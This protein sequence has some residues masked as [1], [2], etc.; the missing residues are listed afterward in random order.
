MCR[1]SLSIPNQVSVGPKRRALFRSV[2]REF[3]TLALRRSA[4]NYLEGQFAT[5]GLDEQV[6]AVHLKSREIT[7]KERDDQIES[8]F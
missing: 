6:G 1:Q 8:L 2:S 3:T 5:A 7:L 4:T